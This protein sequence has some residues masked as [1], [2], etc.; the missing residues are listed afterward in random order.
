[1]WVVNCEMRTV[2]VAL[3]PL[4]LLCAYC[5]HMFLAQRPALVN[6]KDI[7]YFYLKGCLN[8]DFE[9]TCINYQMFF[10]A[11]VLVCFLTLWVEFVVGAKWQQEIPFKALGCESWK[12][13]RKKQSSRS[14]SKS[15]T[16][17]TFPTYIFL[18]FNN[19]MCFKLALFFSLQLSICSRFQCQFWMCACVF[20]RFCLL[21]TEPL[22][23]SIFLPVI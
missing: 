23:Q 8:V 9:A 17:I 10:W 3:R 4:V 14:L 5:V 21:Y 6:T 11:P 19:L 1:M 18:L 13:R 12:F 7:F 2:I 16:I 15:S 22:A 20:Y